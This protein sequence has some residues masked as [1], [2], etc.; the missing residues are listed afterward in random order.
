M[1]EYKKQHYVP[2]FY[3]RN[4]ASDR[5]RVSLYNITNGRFV[6][7][8]NIR[9][10]CYEDYFYGTTGMENL[11][12]Q[13]EGMAARLLS[14]LHDGRISTVNVNGNQ[15]LLPVFVSIMMHRTLAFKCKNIQ[16][17]EGIRN[18]L[19][20]EQLSAD[21]GEMVNEFDE[22]SPEDAVRGSLMIAPYISDLSCV[23]IEAPDEFSF[24]TC[25]NPVVKVNPF[26]EEMKPF[27]SATGLF[28][29]GLILYIP[30]S[31]AK[32]LVF[33][34]GDVYRVSRGRNAAHVICTTSDVRVLNDL[35]YQ[36]AH[37]NLYSNSSAHFRMLTTQSTRRSAYVE[38]ARE[39]LLI[40][41]QNKQAENL[42]RVSDVD[43]KMRSEISILRVRKD[44][45]KERR[46]RSNQRGHAWSRGEARKR[47][48]EQVMN[49]KEGLDIEEFV[50]LF[51]PSFV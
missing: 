24:I 19:S 40:P 8:A 12:S 45:K 7:N 44:A 26:L 36:N 38:V 41:G 22:I 25:D 28:R 11:L 18:D 29:R 43:V 50:N 10:Q 27:G 33:Y 35:E 16:M 46:N 1:A 42:I 48:I 34:D 6:E 3:L 47:Q 9:T 21:V 39:T 32:A 23:L 4:F 5:S 30:L 2:Q 31:P 20:K 15:M 14:D 17:I 49:R 13:I 51:T 37:E